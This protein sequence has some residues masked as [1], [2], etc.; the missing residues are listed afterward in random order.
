MISP[1]Q[2]H[3]IREVPLYLEERVRTL[4]VTSIAIILR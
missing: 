1:A 2:S 3:V 4:E